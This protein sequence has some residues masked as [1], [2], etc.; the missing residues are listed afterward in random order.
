MN[1]RK[2]NPRSQACTRETFTLPPWHQR[3]KS[4]RQ[5][6]IDWVI[7]EL[8]WRDAEL[9][10][11]NIKTQNHYAVVPKENRERNRYESAIASARGGNLA[12]LRKMF[13]DHAEFI[14]EP[15]RVQGQHRPRRISGAAAFEHWVARET[16][17]QAISDV[18]EIRQIWQEHYGRWK[19]HRDDVSAEA[20]AGVHRGMTEDEVKAA[21]KSRSR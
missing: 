15:P 9:S 11:H 1:A 18:K 6:M 12:P 4:D 2:H 7:S 5:A 3:N 13:P 16:V 21:I 14:N 19:R 8:E 17:E 10:E 20:I